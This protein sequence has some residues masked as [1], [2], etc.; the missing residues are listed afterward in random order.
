MFW[1]QSTFCCDRFESSG[2]FFKRVLSF[3]ENKEL[4]LTANWSEWLLAMK[5]IMI[6]VVHLTHINGKLCTVVLK[7]LMKGISSLPFFIHAIFTSSCSLW[8]A[9][10]MHILVCPWQMI[11]YALVSCSPVFLAHLYFSLIIF[12]YWVN[13]VVIPPFGCYPSWVLRKKLASK[14]PTWQPWSDQD[15][16]KHTY[17]YVNVLGNNTSRGVRTNKSS[18]KNP[19]LSSKRFPLCVDIDTDISTGNE[20]SSWMCLHSEIRQSVVW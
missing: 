3:V 9:Y 14:R 10:A 20:Y 13:I 18:L 4:Q 19:S 11:A 5:K 6:L 17:A 7:S 15:T 8:R 2:G 1:A 16:G 12:C